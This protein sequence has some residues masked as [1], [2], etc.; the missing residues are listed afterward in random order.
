VNAWCPEVHDLWRRGLGTAAESPTWQNRLNRFQSNRAR[1]VCAGGQ[2]SSGII[3]VMAG[4]V[5]SMSRGPHMAT[6]LIRRGAR[7]SLRTYSANGKRACPGCALRMAMASCGIRSS[8]SCDGGVCRDFP[9]R[10]L[11]RMEKE[12]HS[13][14]SLRIHATGLCMGAT[15]V[16]AKKEGDSREN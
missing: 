10:L 13:P 5:L 15:C 3:I 14:F 2:S 6:S 16:H 9:Q 11:L 8:W 1:I 12:K 7:L 4:S